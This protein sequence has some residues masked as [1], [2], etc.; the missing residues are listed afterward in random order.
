MR[1]VIGTKRVDLEFQLLI[2]TQKDNKNAL[3]AQNDI[4]CNTKL[5]K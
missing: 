4:L 2:Y 3:V 5:E 1:L